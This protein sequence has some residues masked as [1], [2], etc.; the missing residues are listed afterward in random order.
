MHS[1]C[2]SGLFAWGQRS[3]KLQLLFEGDLRLASI[4]IFCSESKNPSTIV[5]CFAINQS[6]VQSITIAPTGKMSIVVDGGGGDGEGG[7]GDG[8]GGGAKS[9]ITIG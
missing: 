4:C 6:I 1:N 7:G 5:G 2:G 3:R 9:V 8:E